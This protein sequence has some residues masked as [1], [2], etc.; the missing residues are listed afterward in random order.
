M[1]YT[2][3]KDAGRGRSISGRKQ[4]LGR[5]H[6]AQRGER[7]AVLRGRRRILRVL[8]D[9]GGRKRSVLDALAGGDRK[10]LDGLI[11]EGKIRMRGDKRGATYEHA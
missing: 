5:P 11:E 2:P 1:N 7:H 3:R 6:D 8:R 9:S 4:A 10:V